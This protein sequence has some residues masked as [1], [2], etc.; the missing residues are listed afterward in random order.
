MRLSSL[1]L[2]EVAKVGESLVASAVGEGNEVDS[3]DE[4]DGDGEGP[5]FFFRRTAFLGNRD[6]LV[7]GLSTAI[8]C[9][10]DDEDVKDSCEPR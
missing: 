6:S 3:E 5:S 2:E 10:L 8:L 4:G 1:S 7:D 9:F